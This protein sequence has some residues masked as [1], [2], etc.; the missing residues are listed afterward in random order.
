ME[1]QVERYQ[2]DL[3][4]DYENVETRYHEQFVQLKVCHL[5]VTLMDT[6]LLCR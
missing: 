2:S 4:V 1:V 3:S 5:L 6:E